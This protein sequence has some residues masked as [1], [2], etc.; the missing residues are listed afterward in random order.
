[1]GFSIKELANILHADIVTTLDVDSSVI[2]ND[3]EYSAIPLK[4]NKSQGLCFISISKERWSQSHRKELAWHDGNEVALKY[5]ENFDVLITETPV[6]ELKDKKI[7]LIVQN[8]FKTIKILALHARKKMTNTVVGITGSV[9][10]STTR[11][12]MEHL[13]QGKETVVATRGNHNTQSGVPLYGAKLCT[14]PGIGILEISLN[15][16][17]NAGN[18]SE[19]IQPN[20][21]IVTSIGEAHLSTLYST[22]NIA[23]YKS[24]IFSGLQQDGLAIINNDI[25]IN[26]LNILVAAAKQRTNNIKFYSMK[27]E[28]ADLY[29]KEI[30]YERDYTKATFVY[31]RN[32]YSFILTLPSDGMIENTLGA[33]LCLLELGYESSE[34]LEK[35]SNFVSLPRIMEQKEVLT[36]DGRNITIID[37]SHNAAIPSMINAIQTLNHKADFYKGR[38]ILVLGQ[39]ADLGEKSEVL[40][41]KLYNYIIQSKADIVFGHGPYMKKIIRK[42][43]S[44]RVGGWFINA[45]TM[46]TQI[47]FFCSDDSLILLKGSVSG[48]DFQK[49]SIYLPMRLKHSDKVIK[50]YSDNEL[51]NLLQPMPGLKIYDRKRKE[52][53]QHYGYN[54]TRTAEGLGAILFLYS[55]FQKKIENKEIHLNKW[56]TNRGKS[57]NDKPFSSNQAFMIQELVDEIKATQHPSAIYEL[58]YRIFDSRANAYKEIQSIA[59]QHTIDKESI[60]NLTGRYRLKEQQRFD[61]EHLKTLSEMFYLHRK[62][63]PILLNIRNE[64]V[65]GIIFGDI[66]KSIIAYVGSYII[67]GTGFKSE[68]LLTQVLKAIFFKGMIHN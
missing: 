18:Q 25:N 19:V 1:M 26:E 39:V 33:L 45:Q 7:Q 43:P 2:I 67:Y 36:K 54:S 24:R 13:L 22:E 11:L 66:R 4:A 35:L 27:N 16:L 55:L 64:Q 31:K 20:V 65:H 60:M 52:I 6:E 46:S 21:V 57:I 58:A 59:Q 14:N 68:E 50:E 10:K 62:K 44:E 34:L 32:T 5:V 17:N 15:A 37:D 29:L 40:H 28:K 30:Q 47:P 61:L 12:M 49:T 9:G 56:E 42:L 63:L 23:Q 48:S 53:V 3:F 51:V 38:K 8:S 41:E